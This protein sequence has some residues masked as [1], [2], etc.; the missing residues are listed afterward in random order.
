[1]GAQG[2]SRGF[3]PGLLAYSS[4]RVKPG[5]LKPRGSCSSKL[6]GLSLG[7]LNLGGLV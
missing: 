5:G 3:K 6:I 7:V 2:C 4:Y 1:M